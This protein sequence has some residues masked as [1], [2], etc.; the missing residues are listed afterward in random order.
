MVEDF[1]MDADCEIGEDEYEEYLDGMYWVNSVVLP[2]EE[3]IEKEKDF[4]MS[5]YKG[6]VAEYHLIA[7]LFRIGFEGIKLPGDFGF[8]VMST[9]QRKT[10]YESTV[11]NTVRFFQVKSRWLNETDYR[12]EL[13][14]RKTR[15][16]FYVST[17]NMM[18]LVNEKEAFLVLYFLDINNGGIVSNFWLSSYHLR[19]LLA[20]NYITI[21][22]I[23]GKNYFA[24]DA[25]YVLIG[26]KTKEIRG[27]LL[28]LSLQLKQ[29]QQ[30]ELSEVIKLLNKVNGYDTG[31]IKIHK[32]I[33]TS[34]D[35]LDIHNDI[36]K[37]NEAN[38]KTKIIDD[39]RLLPEETGFKYPFEWKEILD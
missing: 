39:I 27:K 29:P 28:E 22:K 6:F 7:E 12:Y 26:Q 25:E 9:H 19:Q 34:I 8:D 23:K 17:R 36:S 2:Y 13:D 35:L 3:L 38:R 15:K 20:E 21:E 18:K 14:T 16:K 1:N 10:L 11:V 5:L 31:L 4:A 24:I 30:N 33:S 37:I 32:N